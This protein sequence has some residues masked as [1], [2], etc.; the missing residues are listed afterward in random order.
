MPVKAAYS[1]SCDITETFYPFQDAYVNEDDPDVNTGSSCYLWVTRA[2]NKR[3]YIQFDFSSI[4]AGSVITSATL[5]LY[6]SSYV[7]SG[8]RTY[9]LYLVNNS[10]DEETITWNSLLGTTSGDVFTSSAIVNTSEGWKSW[11]VTFDVNACVNNMPLPD[12]PY[13]GWMIRD[14]DEGISD[15]HGRQF[16]SRDIPAEIQHL[17]PKLEVIY[18]VD[19]E[20]PIVTIT[21]PENGTVFTEP[22]ITV[23]GNATDNVGI[24]ESG[25]THECSEGSS[26]IGGQFNN[27]I[28]YWEFEWNFTLYDGW[29]KITIYAKDAAGNSGNDI[30]NITYLVNLPPIIS[31][32]NPVNDSTGVVRPPLEL[33]A[34]IEDPNGDFMDVYIK[35]KNHD[36]EWITLIDYQAIGN[37]TYNFVSPYENDWI[38]GDT[39]YVWSVN[40]TD[41]IVWTNETYQYTT[42]GSR[43]DVSN[44]GIVNFQDAGLIWI[45]RT[46]EA[47]YDG[48]YDVNQDGQ[49]NLQDAG[50]TW[51]NRD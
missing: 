16:A 1:S 44:N 5:N 10:W 28:L 20:P 37:G 49:V 21:S 29:N 48:I 33:N 38:W 46:N 23:S 32:K 14:H 4:P 26:G 39:T 17:M 35:W 42:G 18:D 41:E 6:Q 3:T 45:H 36:G 15:S 24:V 13:H 22:H 7:G 30:I 9:D 43:Y 47:P 2:P 51:I 11:D 12:H 50:L 25:C 34:T 31:D 19:D 27:S 8:D 40:V